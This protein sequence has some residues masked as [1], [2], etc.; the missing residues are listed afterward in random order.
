MSTTDRTISPSQS[1]SVHKRQHYPQFFTKQG[2]VCVFVFDE[3]EVI[4]SNAPWNE[5]HR[6]IELSSPI[7][8][9]GKVRQ[10]KHTLVDPPTPF[11][12]GFI[13]FLPHET[14]E[15]YKERVFS[16]ASKHSSFKRWYRRHT[17]TTVSLTSNDSQKL[18]HFKPLNL[19]IA[20]THLDESPLS[21]RSETG[22]VV[23]MREDEQSQQETRSQ[24][25]QQSTN[26]Q[27]TQQYSTHSSDYQSLPDT[28]LRTFPFHPSLVTNVMSYGEEPDLEDFPSRPTE[29][30]TVQQ[31]GKDKARSAPAK[32]S[33]FKDSRPKRALLHFDDDTDFRL[34]VSDFQ[35]Y[36]AVLFRPSDTLLH[37]FRNL[38]SRE[39]YQS[40]NA[41]S[42]IETP[43]FPYFSPFATHHVLP[44][45][46][47][48]KDGNPNSY[49]KFYSMVPQPD[50]Y[51]PHHD[52]SNIHQFQKLKQYDTM[53]SILDIMDENTKLY[54]RRDYAH[55]T[56]RNTP[57]SSALRTNYSNLLSTMSITPY[58]AP[59]VQKPHN[60]ATDIQRIPVLLFLVPPTIHI[61]PH[62][63]HEAE[64][65]SY[66][67]PNDPNNPLFTH[68]SSPMLNFVYTQGRRTIAQSVIPASV[69]IDRFFPFLSSIYTEGTVSDMPYIPDQWSF[70][71]RPATKHTLSNTTE[72]PSLGSLISASGNTLSLQ[73][74]TP[75]EQARLSMLSI[76]ALS[77]PCVVQSSIHMTP[78]R[79]ME[80]N[81]LSNTALSLL[82]L[83]IRHSTLKLAA[84]MEMS[85][86]LLA[87]NPQQ[88]DPITQIIR[89]YSIADSHS[90]SMSTPWASFFSSHMSQSVA[91][92]ETWSMFTSSTGGQSFTSNRTI[93]SSHTT[94]TAQSGVSTQ[95]IRS[96]HTISGQPTRE[97]NTQ[98]EQRAEVAR[99]LR[100]TM[101]D[102][103]A[104]HATS[105]ILPPSDQSTSTSTQGSDEL[106]DGANEIIEAQDQL[107]FQPSRDLFMNTTNSSEVL[108]QSP[109]DHSH[110][111][112]VR[113]PS[114]TL[115]VEENQTEQYEW[116]TTNDEHNLDPQIVAT[117][118]QI[119]DGAYNE[120]AI[121][122]D[123][124]SQSGRH[125]ISSSFRTEAS[126]RRRMSTSSNETQRLVRMSLA[127]PRLD[128]AVV[129][130]MGQNEKVEKRQEGW[131]LAGKAVP[132]DLA[133]VA[134]FL[135]D[136]QEMEERVQTLT[137]S[138][139]SFANHSPAFSA[140]SGASSSSISPSLLS[141]LT[142]FELH[143]LWRRRVCEKGRRMSSAFAELVEWVNSCLNDWKGEHNQ[144]QPAESGN[145]LLDKKYWLP[146]FA[147][148]FDELIDLQYTQEDVDGLL[149]ESGEVNRTEPTLPNN[150]T[151]RDSHFP[152]TAFGSSVRKGDKFR[153]KTALFQMIELYEDT[154]DDLG[155][156]LRLLWPCDELRMK[157]DENLAHST[158]SLTTPSPPT[159]LTTPPTFTIPLTVSTDT[160]LSAMTPQHQLKIE[161]K[162]HKFVQDV[163]CPWM[164][165]SKSIRALFNH[166]RPYMHRFEQ[167][168]HEC[169]HTTLPP[170]APKQNCR[171]VNNTPLVP[172]NGHCSTVGVIQSPHTPILVKWHN[173]SRFLPT[174]ARIVP[175]NQQIVTH[176][177]NDA[178]RYTTTFTPCM[179]MKLTP[180]RFFHSF[181]DPHIAI[182]RP[183]FANI[184]LPL[185]YRSVSIPRSPSMDVVPE[186]VVHIPL[187]TTELE[188]Q[189]FNIS[190]FKES[191]NKFANTLHPFPHA[192]TIGR[193]ATRFV[194]EF[195]HGHFRLMPDAFPRSDYCVT[196]QAF[197]AP[198]FRKFVRLVTD[199]Y[200]KP[201]NMGAFVERTIRCGNSES[202]LALPK[203]LLIAGDLHGNLNALLHVL[204]VV[205]PILSDPDDNH[206]VVFAGDYIDRGFFSL[207]VLSL[208]FVY[209]MKYPKK[210]ILLKGNHDTAYMHQETLY[211]SW[212]LSRSFSLNN[213]YGDASSAIIDDLV[214][215]FKVLPFCAGITLT[216]T[217]MDG[218]IGVAKRVLITHGGI[219]SSL[220]PLDIQAIIGTAVDYESMDDFEQNRM[221][222]SLKYEAALTSL[223]ADP[224]DESI[225]NVNRP[226]FTENATLRFVNS[227]RV[228]L[229]VRGHEMASTGTALLHSGRILSVFSSYDYDV[230]NFLS[231]EPGFYTQSEP[232]SRSMQRQYDIIEDISA[233]LLL[234]KDYKGYKKE[235][236]QA[237]IVLIGLEREWMTKE[238]M[239]KSLG[240]GSVGEQV[241][242][243]MESKEL[244]AVHKETIR[245]SQITITD[246]I[247]EV[248]TRLGH[249]E[250]INRRETML[251]F[252]EPPKQCQLFETFAVPTNHSRNESENRITPTTSIYSSQPNPSKQPE[253]PVQQMAT[254]L[255]IR[256]I[257]YGPITQV[258]QE[259][260]DK[261]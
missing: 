32:S 133:N 122:W 112:T 102:L 152:T 197:H 10:G 44:P 206:V 62:H 194:W 108:F 65:H 150:G 5:K 220:P 99:S 120:A 160:S 172:C 69:P 33:V 28:F 237:A 244:S 236:N 223:W 16:M 7:P 216:D 98:I 252:P 221:Y 153:M 154:W 18:P 126:G 14:L 217:T 127:L 168:R 183:F 71:V 56:I 240:K 106:E 209:A 214:D 228:D 118:D 38:N 47:T 100:E 64:E 187:P 95:S 170:D 247:E 181:F 202:P 227:N 129:E 146:L 2:F 215:L 82:Q 94:R 97:E 49:A 241:V 103:E 195:K 253:G 149:A 1:L 138:S 77:E 159:N 3:P 13:P 61:S 51:T 256:A 4:R 191:L 231:E 41:Q 8:L 165:E 185:H 110:Q 134:K 93:R 224:S 147:S 88:P 142:E 222:R 31:P 24:R 79:V 190:D 135:F 171:C 204:S 137:Q 163:C 29:H 151:T 155:Q 87:A 139:P 169:V 91:E 104:E 89:E 232:K 123:A 158:Q 212:Y 115:D 229:I 242:D 72:V 85:A 245:E 37:C 250:S 243:V 128:Q 164:K 26:S 68:N 90:I 20:S 109:D 188:F 261:F 208:L 117:T 59:G 257:R 6:V 35:V 22:S 196:G 218:E 53:S 148:V 42:P 131:F 114:R 83:F 143:E 36:S 203:G 254:V 60:Y 180:Q 107:V 167:H 205:E 15:Q 75:I 66:P 162:L 258:L 136:L 144:P 45:K 57:P 226:R 174:K 198:E 141:T 48:T 173:H 34:Q 249:A 9:T 248:R 186:S 101:F 80:R 67:T 184:F 179:D 17:N 111:S 19:P 251:D 239:G 21:P 225:P 230:S 238:E 46:G 63:A 210:I 40:L 92:S 54:V 132:R 52:L 125:S 12:R 86:D 11:F 192:T 189:S 207:E 73:P 55:D 84:R 200:K 199:F 161:R 76:I 27:P 145:K 78:E 105:S 119:F 116:D 30:P 182:N 58:Q 177:L 140:D 219:S 156:T 246:W 50:V 113:M 175:P 157:P 193:Q 124:L 166:P 178:I 23:D 235:T 201:E 234:N 43:F 211:W 39:P 255:S 81:F 260:M 74:L 259:E 130:K 121:D 176:P 70:R 25:S 233:Q 213:P 96:S